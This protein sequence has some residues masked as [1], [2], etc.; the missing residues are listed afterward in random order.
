MQARTGVGLLTIAASLLNARRSLGRVTTIL[1]S[2]GLREAHAAD[3]GT[4]GSL[5]ACVEGTLVG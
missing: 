3:R 2:R 4:R 1:G 5:Q